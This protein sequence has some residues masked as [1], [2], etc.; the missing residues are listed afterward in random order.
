LTG[1]LEAPITPGKTGIPPMVDVRRDADGT[2]TVWYNPEYGYPDSGWKNTGV[3]LRAGSGKGS[4]T[5]SGPIL[6]VI[7]NEARG[8]VGIWL[9]DEEHSY[10]RFD[11]FSEAY[12][13][14]VMNNQ[15]DIHEGQTARVLMVVSSSEA[16]IPTGFGEWIDRWQLN[17]PDL[18]ETRA[19]Y[20]QP[21]PNCT[22][23][24][25]LPSGR[26]V[27][28]YI[29]TIRSNT[30]N[31][32]MIGLGDVHALVLN[33]HTDKVPK[34]ISSTRFT[35]NSVL[36]SWSANSAI[37]RPNSSAEICMSQVVREYR[38][39][40]VSKPRIEYDDNVTAD[41]V[42]AGQ[43]GTL[44]PEGI[45]T[46][47]EMMTPPGSG[48]NSRFRVT[49]GPQEG[50]IVVAAKVDGRIVWSWHL[51]V[52]NYD[53]E[54]ENFEYTSTGESRLSAP[55][56]GKKHVFMD[57][58]MGALSNTH[59]SSDDE[60]SFGL[61]YQW[62]RKDPLPGAWYQSRPGELPVIYVPDPSTGGEMATTLPLSNPGMTA[63]IR[64]S[65]EH[66]GEFIYLPNT[67]TGFW[68]WNDL[69][70]ESLAELWYD[71]TD[72]SSGVTKS[73]YDPCPAG[74]RL[75]SKGILEGLNPDFDPEQVIRDQ[76]YYTHAGYLPT[77]GYM[78]YMGNIQQNV[79]RYAFYTSQRDVPVWFS[80]WSNGVRIETT[81]GSQFAKYG[82]NAY[83]A[84]CIKVHS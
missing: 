61:F 16:W 72:V 1:P 31:F 48:L 37:L 26:G 36:P 66:P 7:D 9:N 79:G 74:W 54:T 63:G 60:S 56:A 20:V 52:T 49:T 6:A 45:V 11:K 42:W 47:I 40:F 58:N 51:W 65:I 13:F 78:D 34:L 41:W 29:I 23:E 71:G 10:Y 82:S 5:Q 69:S 18:P 19:G 30:A 2:L 27:G 14:N 59:L 38:A 53:P 64:Y 83:S 80:E 39:G 62:G 33:T 81:G 3:K 46:S 43:P 35:I 12:R 22:I 17:D 70:T 25:I 24:S 84:R 15:I 55:D 76:G 8:V 68:S 28:E 75:P 73:V 44:T 50:N 57:R 77:A 21:C 67:M 32:N 4:I